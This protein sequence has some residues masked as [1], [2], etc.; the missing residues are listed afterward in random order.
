MTFIVFGVNHKAGH[1]QWHSHSMD[2]FSSGLHTYRTDIKTSLD[3][4][5]GEVEPQI[6]NKGIASK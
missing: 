1:E 3:V 5:L 4:V 6:S 2:I